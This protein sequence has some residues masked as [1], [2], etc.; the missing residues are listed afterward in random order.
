MNLESK[1]ARLRELNARDNHLMRQVHEVREERRK[2]QLEISREVH[3]C[4]CVRL[5]GEIQVYDMKEHERRRR[6]T[7]GLGLV[8]ELLSA[9]KDCPHCHGSGVPT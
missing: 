3:P 1:R 4:S 6:E 5:N 2:L 7:F 8:A 9:D